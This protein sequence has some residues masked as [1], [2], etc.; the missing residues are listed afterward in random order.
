MHFVITGICLQ[1]VFLL[2]GTLATHCYG[3][4]STHINLSM[5]NLANLQTSLDWLCG[6]LWNHRVKLFYYCS[7]RYYRQCMNMVKNYDILLT[8]LTVFLFF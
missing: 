6:K 1:M 4:S 2:I 5:F 3:I 7:T 8:F